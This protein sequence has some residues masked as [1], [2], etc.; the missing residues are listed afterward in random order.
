MVQ[1]LE[2]PKST[3]LTTAQVILRVLIDYRP[4]FLL[5]YCTV[6]FTK[7]AQ[8]STNGYRPKFMLEVYR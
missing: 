2:E 1:E 8:G 5:L 3:Q 4:N 7:C 6:H